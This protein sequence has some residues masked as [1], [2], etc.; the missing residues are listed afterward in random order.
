MAK[1]PTKTDLLKRIEELEQAVAD[2]DRI[3]GA[4]REQCT[5]AREETAALLKGLEELDVYL[6]MRRVAVLGLKHDEP[7]GKDEEDWNKVMDTKFVTYG[8]IK[9]L[10]RAI[11]E[12]P[13]HVADYAV[14]E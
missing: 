5:M 11:P 9:P 2:R 13:L 7:Q 3:N 12:V 10:V 8:E 4:V 6:S 1:S 14:A